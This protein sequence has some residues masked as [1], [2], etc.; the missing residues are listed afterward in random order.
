MANFASSYWSIPGPITYC[1][2]RDGLLTFAFFRFWFICSLFELV[3]FINEMANHFDFDKG[4]LGL[5]I[6]LF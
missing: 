3:N 2:D 6:R 4:S 5:D 1:A